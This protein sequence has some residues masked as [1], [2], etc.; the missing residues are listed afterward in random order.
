[1]SKQP[2]QY[3]LCVIEK[4]F[5][6]YRTKKAKKIIGHLLSLRME[7]YNA[8]HGPS[9]IP[10]D[11]Y[12]YIAT[13]LL[14]YKEQDDDIIPLACSRILRHSECVTNNMDF[15]PLS[16]LNNNLNKKTKESIKNTVQQRNAIGQDITFD[17]SF[18]ISPELKGSPES[19]RVIK[20]IL[21]AVLNWHKDNNENYFFASATIKVKTDKL[22]SK[23]GLIPIS[24]DSQY[25]LT[26]V[27]NEP[28]VMM[29]YVNSPTQQATRWM[30]DSRVLWDS[31]ECLL[32][33]K[34]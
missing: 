13:N 23:L 4:P 24:D 30:A 5:S 20:Y 21:G 2:N 1:M 11:K 10:I 27:N 26:N 3:K 34:N 9:V 28:A 32:S 17:S 12:D 25:I 33:I 19:Q 16:L 6:T 7:G 18:T 15:F 8:V 14:L 22:F 31:R 29:K